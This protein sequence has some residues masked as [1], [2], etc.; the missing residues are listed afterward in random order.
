M[1]EASVTLR[2]L[3]E[4][5]R[6]VEGLHDRGDDVDS[7]GLDVPDLVD[8]GDAVVVTPGARISSARMLEALAKVDFDLNRAAVVVA[9][10]D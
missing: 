3:E 2:L 1:S 8:G 5:T 10:G 9:R 7:V 4:Y 6:S